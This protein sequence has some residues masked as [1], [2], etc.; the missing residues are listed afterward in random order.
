MVQSAAALDTIV[1]TLCK[2]AMKRALCSR[3]SPFVSRSPAG[4]SQSSR[5]EP[6]PPQSVEVLGTYL[7]SLAEGDNLKNYG[8]TFADM[9]WDFCTKD[10]DKFQE[11]LMLI[12][13]TTAADREYVHLGV[14]VCQLI[15]ERG[16]GARFRQALMRWFQQEFQAKAETRSVSIEKWL[17]IFSFMCEIYSCVFVSGQPIAVLGRAIFSGIGFLLEQSDRD[18]DE[19]DCICSSLKQCGQYLETTDRSKMDNLMDRFRT[20]VISKE[21]SCRVRC[22]LMEMLELRAMGWNDAQKT[23]EQFY[24]DGVV[25]AIAKDEVGDSGR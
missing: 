20:I 24:V 17:S 21:S 7:R 19:I 11:A 9:F 12:T 6:K 23:L 22:L 25:D 4:K 1:F 16:D 8:A 3:M 2:S 15:I 14:L 18:D 5:P 10:E 13:D